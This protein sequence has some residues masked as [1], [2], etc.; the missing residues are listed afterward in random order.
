[1]IQK[2]KIQM[3]NPCINCITLAM[4]KGRVYRTGPGLFISWAAKYCSLY[5]SYVVKKEEGNSIHIDLK[6]AN[7]L[8][9]IFGYEIEM[10]ESMGCL[11]DR[12]KGH[13]DDLKTLYPVKDE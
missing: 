2:C 9:K 1:L 8:G 11:K 7:E 5:F 13:E 4:C 10:G 12:R 3:E 6:R